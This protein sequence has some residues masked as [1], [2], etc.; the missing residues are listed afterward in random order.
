VRE[1]VANN[2]THK[3]RVPGLS[4]AGK[5]GG[6]FYWAYSQL[7]PLLRFRLGKG[8]GPSCQGYMSQYLVFIPTIC[9]DFVFCIG[10]DQQYSSRI[11]DIVIFLGF[12]AV[13]IN[14]CDNIN[15]MFY[16]EKLQTVITFT[17]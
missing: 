9:I 3:N 17:M 1:D 8:P 16:T 7:F 13:K 14:F 12:L 6:S 10:F 15:N 2:I 5:S 11:L 4:Q